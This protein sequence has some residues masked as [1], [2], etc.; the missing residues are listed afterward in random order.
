MEKLDDLY[1]KCLENLEKLRDQE[2]DPKKSVEINSIILGLYAVWL[3][4]PLPNT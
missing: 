4:V 2:N 1:N 3:R